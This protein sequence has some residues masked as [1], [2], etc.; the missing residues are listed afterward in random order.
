MGRCIGGRFT[1]AVSVR[2]RGAVP[3]ACIRATRCA[4]GLRLGHLCRKGFRFA[5][6]RDGPDAAP[7]VHSNRGRGRGIGSELESTIVG[8]GGR[9]V[10]S[11]DLEG[12]VRPVDVELPAEDYQLAIEAHANDQL[13]CCVGDLKREG[14]SLR[15]KHPSGF[16]LL[17]IAD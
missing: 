1:A 10:I 5:S 11:S 8:E 14:K 15:L 2:A 16:S 6:V 3:S 17:R 12:R 9:V 7:R 4:P 13:V